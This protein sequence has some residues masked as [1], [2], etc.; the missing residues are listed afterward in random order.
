LSGDGGRKGCEQK[1]GQK[2]PHQLA[3][4]ASFHKDPLGEQVSWFN[5]WPNWEMAPLSGC[6]R[7]SRAIR[8]KRG[9]AIGAKEYLVLGWLA[10]SRL[11]EL[12]FEQRRLRRHV[13]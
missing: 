3:G 8:E 12:G 9:L 4:K 5:S 7:R 6:G 10:N 13:A 1:C 2:N 11:G